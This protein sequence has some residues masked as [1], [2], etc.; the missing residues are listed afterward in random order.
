MIT[1]KRGDTLAA[2]ASIAQ[3]S[4]AA[5]DLTGY[6]LRSQVRSSSGELVQAL[7]VV[8]TAPTLG[9]YTLSATA[10][11]TAAWPIGRHVCDV[12]YTSAGGVVSSTATFPVIV[13]EDVTR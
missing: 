8:V 2:A 11:Q 1:I 4:G 3:D 7:V 5:V 9:T 12:E 13:S 6:T 10:T